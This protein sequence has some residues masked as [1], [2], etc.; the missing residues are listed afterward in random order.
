MVMLTTPL[1]GFLHCVLLSTLSGV[2]NTLRETNLPNF[3][4]AVIGRAIA[5]RHFNLLSVQLQ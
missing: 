1:C 3:S 5:P 2:F 4:S